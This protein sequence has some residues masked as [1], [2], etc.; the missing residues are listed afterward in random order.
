MNPY[1]APREKPSA[2]PT[3]AA[4]AEVLVELGA[5]PREAKPWLYRLLWRLGLEARP[6]LYAGFL[7]RLFIQALPF[8]A[9]WTLTMRLTVWR[10]DTPAIAYW[11]SLAA[12]TF[13]MI[14]TS[15]WAAKRT[16]RSKNL[17]DWEQVQALAAERI[18][19]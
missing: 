13:V 2:P 16:R 19:S 7:H 3:M 18:R 4:C 12:M 17:P 6:A 8:G 10:H 1:E 9:I 14:L 11:V 5:T 15:A